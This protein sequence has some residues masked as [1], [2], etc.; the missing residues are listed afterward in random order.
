M[1]ARCLVNTPDAVARRGASHFAGRRFEER[2]GIRGHAG[3]H[4]GSKCG[5]IRARA[6]LIARTRSA[7]KK[8][9]GHGFRGGPNG[10]RPLVSEAQNMTLRLVLESGECA[11]IL[12][13]RFQSIGVHQQTSGTTGIATS[14]APSVPWVA[15]SKLV[16][17]VVSATTDT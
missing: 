3:A 1:A 11:P 9:D 7:I 16:G 17:A 15:G 13:P 5:K 2:H 4:H 6:E 10:R 14:L 12:A 8:S